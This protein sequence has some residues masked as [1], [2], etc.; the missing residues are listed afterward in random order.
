MFKTEFH[1]VITHSD[2]LS[3]PIV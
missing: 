2:P 3:H 1:N